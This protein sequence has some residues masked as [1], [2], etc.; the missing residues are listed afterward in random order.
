MVGD[1]IASCAKE[2][3]SCYVSNSGCKYK[4]TIHPTGH[5]PGMAGDD[6]NPGFGLGG[7]ESEDLAAS[8]KKMETLEQTLIRMMEGLSTRSLRHIRQ[9]KTDLRQMSLTM[10]QLKAK[11]SVNYFIL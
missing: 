8:I 5:C 11:S 10:N 2:E 6:P 7:H 4:V 1:R 3:P 9:I